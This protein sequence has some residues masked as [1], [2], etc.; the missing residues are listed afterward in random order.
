MN[1]RLTEL[2]LPTLH[3]SFIGV[4][5]ILDRMAA[6]TVDAGYPP[7]NIVKLSEDEYC[8]EIAVAG[9]PKEGICVNTHEG[10]LTVEAN[11]ERLAKDADKEYIHKG[12]A[13]RR[14]ARTFNLAEHVEVVE[15]HVKDGI[16]SIVLERKVPEELKP[17][18]IPVNFG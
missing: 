5:R 17:R 8:I 9:I 11:I 7:Y 10:I 4:D 16:L 15:A 2:D 14:F 13:S 6:N 18:L 1:A 12:I 3:R